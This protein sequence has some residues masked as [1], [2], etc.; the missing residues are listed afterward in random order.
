MCKRLIC[1]ASLVLVLVFNG[2]SLGEMI[3]YWTFDDPTNLGADSS[4]KGNHG[5][6]EGDG[7][8]SSDAMIGTGALMLDGTDDYIRVGLGNG[9]MLAGWTSDLTIAAWMKPDSVSREWNCFFGHTTENNGVKFELMAGNFRFTTLGVQD[10]DLTVSP[11]FQSGE[12]AHVALTFSKQYLATFYVNGKKVGEI[13]G[14]AP[15]GT[16]TGNY[17]IGYGG[18]WAAEQFQGLLDEVRIYNRALSAAEVQVLAFWPEAHNPDPADGKTG[19][20]T[21]VLQWKAGDT[22]ASHDV[23]FGT[24]PTPGPAEYKGRQVLG[25]TFYYYAPGFTPGTTY[26]WRIDEVEADGVTIHTG[27]VWSFTA[28]PLTA[29]NPNPADG[30]QMGG[31]RCGA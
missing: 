29:Y 1:S 18:Y 2:L 5:T 17:N 24:N 6:V 31:C 4:G 23:Y 22:A 20:L 8:F 25:Y 7:Q 16:A 28:A 26:Y 10:Y 19:V 14:S 12:W 13:P 27:D 15:A 11:A 9:N 21:P 3:G 30:R